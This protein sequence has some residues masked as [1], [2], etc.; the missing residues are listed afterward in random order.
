MDQVVTEGPHSRPLLILKRR[1]DE[2]L[3][4]DGD[5]HALSGFETSGLDLI[6]GK[7]AGSLR[8]WEGRLAGF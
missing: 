3:V 7:V 4:F 1:N 2:F 6:H 5:T 8:R